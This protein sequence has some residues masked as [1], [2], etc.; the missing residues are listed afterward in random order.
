MAVSKGQRHL[1]LSLVPDFTIQSTIGN[2]THYQTD[3]LAS[4][5]LPT[6]NHTDQLASATPRIIDIT[7]QAKTC[8]KTTGLWTARHH[9]YLDV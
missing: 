1:C 4:A 5:T 2:S 9:L 8:R 7:P 3:Q 6:T